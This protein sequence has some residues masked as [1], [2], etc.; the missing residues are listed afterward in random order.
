M[1]RTLAWDF[2]YIAARRSQSAKGRTGPQ[3]MGKRRDGSGRGAV[4]R[5][6]LRATRALEKDVGKRSVSG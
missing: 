4:A 1:V 6:R 3:P 2:R 5:A